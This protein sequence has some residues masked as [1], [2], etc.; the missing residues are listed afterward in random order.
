[1]TSFSEVLEPLFFHV[2]VTHIDVSIVLHS[3]MVP[4]P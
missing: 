1:M 2:P 3:E 4:H